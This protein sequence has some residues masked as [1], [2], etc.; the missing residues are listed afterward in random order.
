M[1]RS[2]KTRWLCGLSLLCLLL[3]GCGAGKPVTSSENPSLRRDKLNL[4][5]YKSD[6]AFWKMAYQEIPTVS[7]EEATGE[8]YRGT[9]VCIDTVGISGE[10]KSFSTD[11]W[12]EAD[13]ELAIPKA[14]GSYYSYRNRII[15]SDSYM[16][17]FGFD[18]LCNIHEGD[19]IKLCLYLKSD[20][21]IEAYAVGAKKTG[22]DSDFNIENYRVDADAQI[23]SEEEEAARKES[24]KAAE[25]EAEQAE[26][27]E[28][29][30]DNP[31]MMAE[32]K[33]EWD[34]RDKKNGGGDLK[35]VY[36]I[37]VAKGEAVNQS[38]GNY[39]EWLENRVKQHGD[40]YTCVFDDG[41]GIMYTD[42]DILQGVYGKVGEYYQITEPEGY[43]YYDPDTHVSR[44]EEAGAASGSDNSG[45]NV[46]NN[47]SADGSVQLQEGTTYVLNTSTRKFHRPSC[48]SVYDI[49]PENREEY[50]GSRDEVIA[51]GY[52]PCGRCNP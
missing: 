26:Y 10:E 17:K 41:T 23:E 37:T 13:V 48:A 9:Y 8:D 31:Y 16:F 35:I 40:R 30:G 25:E 11:S 38:A 29:F 12:K 19:E 3:T 14:D 36:Y 39:A 15:M 49:A 44:Y 47:H 7:F 2:R 5:Y 50:T 1:R 46:S 51:R 45:T 4:E 33:I 18:V 21:L 42:K 22:T 34:D 6:N 24:E 27:K 28:K 52:D 32:E 20:N 43:I